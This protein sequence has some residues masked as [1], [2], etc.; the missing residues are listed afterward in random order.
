M[1]QVLSEDQKAGILSG[2]PMGRMGQAQEVAA[3]TAFLA[4]KEAGYVTGQTLG[5]DGG[6]GI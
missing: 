6:M 3:L 4:S 1:T 2:I 5:I